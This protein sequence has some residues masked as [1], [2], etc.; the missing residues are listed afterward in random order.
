MV[1]RASTADEH[2]PA[3]ALH[4]RAVGARSPGRDA[5]AKIIGEIRPG[6]G[7]HVDRSR[8][9]LANGGPGPFVRIGEAS[10]PSRSSDDR[11]E[12]VPQRFALALQALDQPIRAATAGGV[13]LGVELADPVPVALERLR[14]DEV[15][16][17]THQ[18]CAAA[19]LEGR[20]L[21]A[22]TVEERSEVPDT[23]EVR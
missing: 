4:V 15:V 12:L 17:R 5:G 1:N 6:V 7:D 19:Q 23:D 20:D 3:A 22:G 9:R 8:D 10:R 21:L 2:P 14:V 16:R 13:Q 18:V 11:R